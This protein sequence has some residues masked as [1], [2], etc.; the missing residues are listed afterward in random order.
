M[1]DWLDILKQLGVQ[2]APWTLVVVLILYIFRERLSKGLNALLDWLGT[3]FRGEWSYRR[4]ERI[5]RP[6]TRAMHW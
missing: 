4:F 2:I 6:A 1:N 3:I 5:F